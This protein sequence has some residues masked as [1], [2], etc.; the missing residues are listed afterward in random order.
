MAYD[1][2]PPQESSSSTAIGITVSGVPTSPALVIE[3]GPHRLSST[4]ALA[5]E[6]LSPSTGA[7][8]SPL[9]K[10]GIPLIPV[11]PLGD[12]LLDLGV[13]PLPEGNT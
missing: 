7:L 5:L 10:V 3:D 1:W 13:L 11:L 6:V 4:A 2:L 9:D 8:A 12:Q